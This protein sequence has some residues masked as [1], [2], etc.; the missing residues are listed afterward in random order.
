M[1]IYQ[2]LKSDH[3]KLKKILEEL[4][5]L[6]KEDPYRTTLIED[7]GNQLIPHI[8]AEESTFYNTLRAVHADK[9][10]LYHAFQEHIEIEGLFR[11]L[12]ILDKFN[13]QW[14]PTAIKLK[15]LID[16]HIENEEMDLFNEGRSAFTKDESDLLESSFQELKLKI[17][18][19]G[20]LQNTFEMVFN[21]LPPRMTDKLSNLVK[22]VE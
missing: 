3:E 2:T 8:R 6:E 15:N 17:E 13:L 16:Q 5:R 10:L 4:I 18:N 19:D 12:Q 20:I 21:L 14:L 11:S 9:K 22:R 7:L 1:S